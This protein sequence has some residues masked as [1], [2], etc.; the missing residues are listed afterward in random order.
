MGILDIFRKKEKNNIES[1][2]E[3]RQN[4]LQNEVN[5]QMT[6]DGNLQVDFYDKKAN[7]KQLY[8]STRLVIKKTINLNGDYIQDCLVSWYNQSDAEYFDGT[9]SRHD[10]QNVLADIDYQR[11][12]TDAA[13]CQTVMTELLDKS[14]VEKYLNRGLEEQPVEPPCGNYVGGLRWKDGYWGK[15]FSPRVGMAVHNSD[16]MKRK[17]LLHKQ[18]QEYKKQQQIK[19]RQEQ[20]ERLQKEIQ[21]IDDGR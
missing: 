5:Y 12:Q 9:D 7:F 10:F 6:Q 1:T 20:I 16:F 8:D 13:Y 14:R 3:A 21:E 19:A 4:N 15:Y 17:R 18:E 2:K 11:L